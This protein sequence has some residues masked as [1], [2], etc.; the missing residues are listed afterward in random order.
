MT[1]NSQVTDLKMEPVARRTRSSGRFLVAKPDCSPKD[2]LSA[3]LHTP[4]PGEESTTKRRG[5]GS[6]PINEI[7]YKPKRMFRELP[8]LKVHT[9]ELS[10]FC[11]LQDQTQ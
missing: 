8:G 3:A 10:K 4:L 1:S 7:L 11:D 5:L 2:D 6:F 9:L